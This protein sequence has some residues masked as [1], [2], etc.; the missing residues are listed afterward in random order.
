MQ[1]PRNANGSLPD[2]TGFYAPL[3]EML[4]DGDERVC[5]H[6]CGRWMKAVGG[7]HLRWHGWTIDDYREAFQLGQQTPV[8]PRRLRR[9]HAAL[10]V[11]APRG[12]R[13]NRVSQAKHDR[14]AAG[15]PL[16]NA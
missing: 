2:G 3:G 8:Q 9:A 1:D 15:G 5:C 12:A 4:H 10:A 14:S 6:L 11:N 7:T 13:A 16:S